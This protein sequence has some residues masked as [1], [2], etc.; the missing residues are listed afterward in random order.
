MDGKLVSVKK[1]KYPKNWEDLVQHAFS[2]TTEEL[3]RDILLLEC[4]KEVVSDS[5]MDDALDLFQ[6]RV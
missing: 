6:E 5:T 3:Y 4:L 1:V 2:M